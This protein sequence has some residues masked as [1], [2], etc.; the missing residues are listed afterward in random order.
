VHHLAQLIDSFSRGK[1]G[2]LKVPIADAALIDDRG[3]VSLLRK[4]EMGCI[5]RLWTCVGVCDQG[6]EGWEEHQ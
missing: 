6:D 1:K 4:E 5:L 3:G 2:M